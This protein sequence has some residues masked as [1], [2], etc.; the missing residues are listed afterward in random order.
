VKP[1]RLRVGGGGLALAGSLRLGRVTL[2]LIAGPCAL[3]CST[4]YQPEPS[5]R[6]GII[7][8]H[9]AALYVKNGQAFPVGP[10]GGA[11]E[12]LVASSPPAA[13]RAHRAYEQLAAGIPLYLGGAAS[14][15][16]GLTLVRSPGR[17][18][19]IGA[20]T[21][22]AVTGLGL[23]GAGFSNAVDAVNIY[24]DSVSSPDAAR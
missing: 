18:A 8:H 2:A 23:L 24:N 10:L 15:I 14:L 1:G 13:L 4:T 9:G 3:A 21:A 6:I 22:S 11:L 12:P 16:I 20:G 17:W 5:A 7:I 19:L